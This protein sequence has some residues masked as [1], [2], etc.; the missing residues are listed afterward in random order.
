LSTGIQYIFSIPQNLSFKFSNIPRN[1]ND[2]FNIDCVNG[3]TSWPNL[4]IASI[5]ALA[6]GYYSSYF[7]FSPGLDYLKCSMLLRFYSGEGVVDL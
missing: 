7:I 6:L 2:K 3:A 1:E 4:K 5:G